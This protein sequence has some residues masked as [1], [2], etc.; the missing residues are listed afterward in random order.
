MS[1]CIYTKLFWFNSQA[2]GILYSFLSV[3][4]WWLIFSMPIFLY[5]KQKNHKFKVSGNLIGQSFQR[6]LLT[7]REIK[8]Y[9]PVLIFLIA[10]WFYIDA[11]DTIVRMAVAYG[12]DLGFDSSQLIIA[13][14][15]TQ[16]MGFLQ[17]LHMVI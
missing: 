17:H 1:W 10:Y 13:L 16:F 5:V 7:F 14:I 8:K 12:T 3:A 11:I 4:L 6:I 9:K 15:F 2:E